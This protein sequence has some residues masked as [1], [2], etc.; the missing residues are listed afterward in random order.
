MTKIEIE[1]GFLVW[2][3]GSGARAIEIFDIA[4]TSERRKGVGRDLVRKL[5]KNVP[6][7]TSLVY[8]ITRI[9]NTVAQQF[10]EGIGFR[11]LGRLHNFYR[12]G[13]A[14]IESALV[15]GLDI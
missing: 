6:N 10:Y 8:A 12:D 2:R 4:V 1:G 13:A 7:N 5:L 3:L 11:L 14:E 15:Y 9:G